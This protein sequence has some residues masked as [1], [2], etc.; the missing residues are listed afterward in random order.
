MVMI[1]IPNS[2][3]AMIMTTKFPGYDIRISAA[4]VRP[5][6]RKPKMPEN[7]ERDMADSLSCLTA[8]T[9]APTT[10]GHQVLFEYFLVSLNPSLFP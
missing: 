4:T 2:S 7:R 1:D 9:I 8:P 6:V 10:A 5:N 3:L